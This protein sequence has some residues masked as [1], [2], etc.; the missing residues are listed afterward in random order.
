MNKGY[1]LRRLSLITLLGFML[2]GCVHFPDLDPVSEIE[3]Q[4]VRDRF[5]EMIAAQESC[6][7]CLDGAVRASFDN[8]FDAG[9]V[10]GYLQAMSPSYLKFIAM[11]PLGQ[12]LLI[13]TSDGESFQ[14]V[15]VTK[16]VEYVG[17]VTGQTFQKYAP[18]GFSPEFTYYWF[19]GRLRPGEVKI[20]VASR[21]Q[22]DRGYWIDLYYNDGRKNMV[23]FDPVTLHIY[24]H[25]VYNTEGEVLLEILYDDYSPESCGLPLSI[26]V[27]SLTWDTTLALTIAD[28]VDNV[29]LSSGDF[30]Y[31]LPAAFKR[32]V[33]E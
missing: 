12:P 19:T 6:H 24:H 27:K 26:T 2:T 7:C 31:T 22:D 25:L 3:T 23:L 14:Y 28:L 4:A 11:S 1:F 21:A 13:L 30:S 5:K 20:G 16:Q 17:S 18:V 15:D 9:S 29:S 33:V 8:F 10:A 32:E